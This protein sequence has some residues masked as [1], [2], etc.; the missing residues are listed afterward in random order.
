MQVLAQYTEQKPE[1]SIEPLEEVAV[2]TTDDSDIA[3]LE[4]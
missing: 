4:E 3:P 2:E 1:K